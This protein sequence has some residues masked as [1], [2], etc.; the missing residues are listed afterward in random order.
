M[1]RPV[2]RHGFTVVTVN[3]KKIPVRI[4]LIK[5]DGFIE[6][7]Y[8]EEGYAFEYAYGGASFEGFEE[9]M[10]MAVRNAK[11]WGIHDDSF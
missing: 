1:D 3:G 4:M 7:Y 6:T 2:V 10:K 9:F 5:Y 11:D 8:Q